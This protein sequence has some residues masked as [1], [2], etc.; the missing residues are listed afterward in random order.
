MSNEQMD[1]FVED[2]RRVLRM[3]FD[4]WVEQCWAEAFHLL[5]TR[6]LP[7]MIIELILSQCTPSFLRKSIVHGGPHVDALFQAQMLDLL[8]AELEHR[9]SGSHLLPNHAADLSSDPVHSRSSPYNCNSGICFHSLAWNHG[10]PADDDDHAMCLCQL[11]ACLDCFTQDVDTRLGPMSHLP[12]ELVQTT[13]RDGWA[14]T[15]ESQ[16]DAEIRHSTAATMSKPPQPEKVPE[17]K[18]FVRTKKQK[19]TKPPALFAHPQMTDVLA[20]EEH[21]RWRLKEMG[22]SDP[23]VEARYGPCTSDPV[24]FEDVVFPVEQDEEDE[25]GDSPPQ[26]GATRV[27]PRKLLKIKG[28]GGRRR[29]VLGISNGG[30]KEKGDKKAKTCHLPRTWTDEEARERNL[31]IVLTF[32]HFVQLLYSIASVSSPFAYPEYVSDV[33]ELE[34]IHPVALYRQMCAVCLLRRDFTEEN[35]QWTEC[36]DKWGEELAMR[37]K[38]MGNTKVSLAINSPNRL[39]PE[40]ELSYCEAIVHYTHALSLDPKKTVY[41]TNRAVALNYLKAYGR[42]ESD[43]GYILS[44]DKNNAKAY[45]Q[46][47]LARAGLKR[48]RDAESDVKE[49]LRLQPGNESAKRVLEALRGE[50]RKLDSVD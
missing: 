26:T 46:R 43:C 12:F 50:V 37:E 49:V 47:A 31:A 24:A 40:A 30:K 13:A 7:T 22:A 18:G 16:A 33:D 42:A 1:Q 41:Y 8:Y 34:R 19:V 17:G 36:M 29:P 35:N 28:K 32:R 9:L 20:V 15:L 39:D 10:Q 11:T 3:E 45:Y 2:L 4:C 6:T 14:G 23:A 48:W 5:F 21:L 25:A 27:G 38:S 44:K